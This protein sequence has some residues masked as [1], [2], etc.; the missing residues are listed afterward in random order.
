MIYAESS[1]WIWAT[2]DPGTGQCPVGFGH[3]S[4]GCSKRKTLGEST[5]ISERQGVWLG[6]AGLLLSAGIMVA[7]GFHKPMQRRSHARR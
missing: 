6:V 2:P 3:N 7:M 4:W 1:K 5:P